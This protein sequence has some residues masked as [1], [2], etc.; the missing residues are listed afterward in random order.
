M[1]GPDVAKV[2]II[3]TILNLLGQEPVVDLSDAA[4][5]QSI[6]AVKALRVIEDA[7]DTVLARHGWV[8]ALN[9]PTLTP[10]VIAG[11]NNWRYPT[12]YLLPGDGVAVWEIEGVCQYDWGPRWQVGTV[13][14][15][16]GSRTV[17]RAQNGAAQLN[18]AYIRRATWAALDAHVRDAVAYDGASRCCYS[19]TGVEPTAGFLARVEN[20]ILQAIGS[21]ATQ[22]GNQP[23]MVPSIP[24][25]IR[26][27]GRGSGSAG[28]WT[29]WSNWQG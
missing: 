25:A 3:N 10:A 21:D 24:E 9:Y 23:P 18:V 8:C 26:N 1:S 14:T 6:A 28:V 2:S 5:A 7:R 4:L 13:E 11:Y 12:T 15:D 22:E 29:G 17:I 20:K 16:E 19:I 27:Y